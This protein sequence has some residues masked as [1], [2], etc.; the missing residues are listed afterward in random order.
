MCTSYNGVVGWLLCAL[1]GT[2]TIHA[3]AARNLMTAS[4]PL[5]NPS[6]RVED[7]SALCGPDNNGWVC[8]P[9]RCCSPW[10]W[11]GGSAPWCGNGCQPQYGD[12]WTDPV[13]APTHGD[14]PVPTY[15]STPPDSYN[16]TIQMPPTYWSFDTPPG[17]QTNHSEAYFPPIPA[18][19]ALLEPPPAYGLYGGPVNPPVVPGDRIEH[20][21]NQCGHD[22]HGWM[23]GPGRCCSQWGWCGSVD[24]YC[25]RGC[26]V[27]FGDCW[28]VDDDEGFED[29]G[30]PPANYEN[31]TW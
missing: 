1:V 14:F 22:N 26:Q 20:P 2:F 21:S 16:G 31:Y 23:C 19:Y 30:G 8:G 27:E 15:G 18:V 17:E 6:P 10:G 13:N 12:C 3:T 28:P 5:F 4:A 9:S 7:P 24:E 25:S 11:C 29:E